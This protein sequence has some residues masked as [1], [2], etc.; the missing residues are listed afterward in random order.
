MT[1]PV[2]FPRFFVTTPAPCPYLPG[3]DERKVFTELKGDHSDELND[4]LGRIGFRRSQTVAYRPSCVGCN[5]C[6]SVRVAAID[7]EP[8]NRM[9]AGLAGLV[10]L[11]AVLGFVLEP[12]AG[13]LG[14]ELPKDLLIVVVGIAVALVGLALGWFVP[15]DSLLGPARASAE[16]GFRIGGGFKHL[17]ARPALAVARATDT[18][19]GGIH[20]GVL[21]VGHAGLAVARASRFTDEKGI[22]GLIF[23]LVR[24]TRDLGRRARRLQTGLVHKELLL[25]VTGGVLILAFVAIGI[26]VP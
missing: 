19:D 5:A 10:G 17:V 16:N 13:L 8:S 12:L 24:G 15:A 2:R 25:A 1:A 4:A 6:V 14:G 20:R 26:L 3:R 22:D 11:A 9:G 18:F 21:G 23:A 7:F